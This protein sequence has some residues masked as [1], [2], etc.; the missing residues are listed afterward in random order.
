[1]A[2][3]AKIYIGGMGQRRVEQL[4]RD[5]NKTCLCGSTALESDTHIS[6][7]DDGSAD[8]ELW[9]TDYDHTSGLTAQVFKLSSREVRRVRTG[10]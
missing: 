6:P 7:L 1:M 4:A 2:E 9:C 5:R 3:R 8:V 10:V